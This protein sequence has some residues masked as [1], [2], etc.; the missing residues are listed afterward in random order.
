MQLILPAPSRI[1]L[2]LCEHQSGHPIHQARCISPHWQSKGPSPY[3]RHKL[4]TNFGCVYQYLVCRLHRL[5]QS[6]THLLLH[7]ATDIPLWWPW[8]QFDK[9]LATNILFICPLCNAEANKLCMRAQYIQIK[10]V[11]GQ[12]QTLFYGCFPVPRVHQW[13]IDISRTTCYEVGATSA[14]PCFC[15]VIK[16]IK[17]VA[18]VSHQLAIQ[19]M[20]VCLTN[21]PPGHTFG[22]YYRY[23]C[24]I[25]VDRCISCRP[26]LPR[27]AA[28]FIR[29]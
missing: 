26:C 1:V 23:V 22:I 29:W 19:T 27:C 11:S 10:Q 25:S 16:A 28:Q 18:P 3:W 24:S 15:Y 20:K 21:W 2:N 5:E 17:G 13:P 9:S 8:C 6:D 12:W 4:Q 14:G 7:S